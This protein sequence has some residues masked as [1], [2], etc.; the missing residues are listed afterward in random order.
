LTGIGVSLV[1]LGSAAARPFG[2]AIM[3][4]TGTI[5]PFGLF[6][7][8]DNGRCARFEAVELFRARD[9]AG[10]AATAV[11]IGEPRPIIRGSKL[12]R[13][14]DVVTGGDKAEGIPFLLLPISYYVETVQHTP[15]TYL[16]FG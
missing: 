3:S 15:A 2:T 5:A 12:G 13:I 16:F 1:S 9:V 11:G 14:G 8:D 6:E 10:R 7:A 4:G